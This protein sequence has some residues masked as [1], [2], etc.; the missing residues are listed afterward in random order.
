[1]KLRH[2]FSL[3]NENPSHHQI[4]WQQYEERIETVSKESKVSKFC[5]DA[6]F[7]HVV[8]IGQCFMTK[9]TD[10]S[11]REFVVN[12]FFQEVMNHHNQEDG[13]RETQELDPC[14]KL[15]SVA[16]MENTEFEI[17]IWSLSQDNSHSWVR[18][19]HGSNK[20]VIDSNYN[21]TEILAD[22]Q[23]DQVPQTNIKVV[24]ARSKAESKPQKREIVELPSYI[25]MNEAIRSFSL[26]VRSLEESDQFRLYQTVQREEDGAIDF[27]RIKIFSNS[28]ST[29]NLLVG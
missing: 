24:A 14:R 16:G 10:S 3:Q 11:L 26:C 9:D 21:K 2:K 18:I 5:L 8:E 22:P 1:M 27:W 15:Q 19:S 12:T 23:E 17:R 6:G 29:N 20:F 28:I 25:P 7:I 4:L 13:F